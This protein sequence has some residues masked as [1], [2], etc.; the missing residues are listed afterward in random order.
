MKTNLRQGFAFTSLSRYLA[1]VILFA[2]A[3]L[4]APGFLSLQNVMNL[5]RSFSVHTLRLRTDGAIPAEL[6]RDGAESGGWWSLPFDAFDQV[7]P[8]LARIRAAGCRIDDLEIGKP[9][10]EE[11]FVRVMQGPPQGQA[12]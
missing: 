12:N 1:L 6:A 9:D 7:E 11:V 5:L 10:L 8:M 4:M 3:S 2:V